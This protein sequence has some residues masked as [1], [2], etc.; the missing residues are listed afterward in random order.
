MNL[1]GWNALMSSYAQQGD[2]DSVVELFSLMEYRGLAPDGYTFLS[3][4]TAFCNAGF[5]TE[6]EQW[7]KRM[8]L[9]YKLEPLIEHYTCLVGALGRSAAIAKSMVCL[10]LVWHIQQQQQFPVFT[11]WVVCTTAAVETKET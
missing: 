6:T 8:E 2:K 3:I 4:T 9:E 5:A 10:Q 11:T 1:V 7:F